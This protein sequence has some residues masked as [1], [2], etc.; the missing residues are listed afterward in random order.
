MRQLIAMEAARLMAEHGVRDYY[1]AKRKAAE[2]LGAAETQNIPGND[3][4]EQALAAYQ[5]LFQAHKQPQRL[6][7]L[8]ET[9]LHAMR[10]FAR[11]D[12]RL[13][14]SVLSGT[15]HEHST[16]SLHLFTDAPQEIGLFLEQ[17]NIPFETHE[18]HLRL[19]G[20]APTVGYPAYR[21]MAGET[22]MELTIFPVS[23]LRQAPRSPIDGRPMQRAALPAVEKLLQSGP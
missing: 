18:H 9:A 14:G 10:F 2:Q 19:S 17:E 11:F 13:V 23:G 3:E 8:R 4:I 15:A 1:A 21:F 12:A 16:V 6:R 22:V 5:R 20:D 7:Q